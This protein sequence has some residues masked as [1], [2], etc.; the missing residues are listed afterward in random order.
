[1]QAQIEKIRT[2]I[3]GTISFNMK[4]EGMRKFQD[5]IVYPIQ[6]NDSEKVITIQSDTRI[7][8]LNLNTGKGEMSQSHSGGAYFPHLVMDKK[9]IFELS[10]LDLQTLK[11][12]IQ[13][14]EPIDKMIL[15]LYV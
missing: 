15:S 12:I 13:F 6:K 5:F 14:E 1:M 10:L 2:N 4:I 3:M 8:R 11:S 7:G 9:T